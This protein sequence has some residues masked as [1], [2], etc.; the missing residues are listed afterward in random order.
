M[1]SSTAA[2]PADTSAVSRPARNAARTAAVT[3]SDFV[4]IARWTAR[5]ATGSYSN[6]VACRSLRKS[7]QMTAASMA[8]PTSAT[9]ASAAANGR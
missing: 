3:S 9:G 2:A 1:T 8:S 4:I 6:G 7:I 5:V